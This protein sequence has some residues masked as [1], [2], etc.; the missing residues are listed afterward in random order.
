[1]RIVTTPMER[2]LKIMSTRPVPATNSQAAVSPAKATNVSPTACHPL[3]RITTCVDTH[4]MKASATTP[5]ANIRTCFEVHVQ[6]SHGR[7]RTAS[8]TAEA[9][10]VY[11]PLESNNLSMTDKMLRPG[12]HI[13]QTRPLRRRP[14]LLRLRR[15]HLLQRRL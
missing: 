14:L 5:T 11:S 15:Q 3:P 9:T 7:A 4:N 1:M 2:S 10:N 8:N 13:R 6:T 12:R